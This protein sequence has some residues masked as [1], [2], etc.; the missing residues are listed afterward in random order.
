MNTNMTGLDG[1][2]ISLPPCALDKSSD[3]IVRVK[4][5][6]Q[7]HQNVVSEV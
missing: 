4:E 5:F 2:Q 1:Y 3:S 7:K 6:V